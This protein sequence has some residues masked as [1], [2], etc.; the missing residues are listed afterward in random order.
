M[1]RKKGKYLKERYFDQ[2]YC[3]GSGWNMFKKQ[4]KYAAGAERSWAKINAGKILERNRI[5]SQ[6]MDRESYSLCYPQDLAV[7]LAHSKCVFNRFFFFIEFAHCR[8]MQLP[9]I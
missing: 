2:K 5:L 1:G 9:Q 4:A 8:E 6:G 3:S 7:C